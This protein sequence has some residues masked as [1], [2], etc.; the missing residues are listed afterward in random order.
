MASKLRRYWDSDCC[1]GYLWNQ[2]DRQ[3]AC[4]RVLVEAEE[5]RCEV[6]ISALTI[7]EVLHLRGDKREFRK[8]S[9]DLI[10]NFFRRS[11][12]VIADVDRFIA[13]RAQ[14]AFWDHN[15]QP[16]DAIHLATSLAHNA[17]Y[18][19]T[20]DKL[21]LNLSRKVGGDPQ[22][23]TQNPGADLAAKETL[24]REEEIVKQGLFG[25]DLDGSPGSLS[26]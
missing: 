24:R 8:E 13:E 19:E 25:Q 2:G 5:G 16:K 20:Y 18:L 23:V 3:A 7:A 9:K 22:L 11:Y 26:R 21:L 15:I 6:M 14:D 17:Y 4:D 12:I 1:F 10:R